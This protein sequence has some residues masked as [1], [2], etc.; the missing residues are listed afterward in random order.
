MKRLAQEQQRDTDAGHD[1]CDQQGPVKHIAPRQGEIRRTWRLTLLFTMELINTRQ[2]LV[3]KKVVG[4]P[5]SLSKFSPCENMMVRYEDSTEHKEITGH[6]E[7]SGK[8]ERNDQYS[9][10]PR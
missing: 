8:R 10:N 2:L 3:Q 6:T 1:G 9:I 7:G 4:K 5:Q